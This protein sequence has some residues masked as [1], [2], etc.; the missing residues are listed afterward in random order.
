VPEFV[1]PGQRIRAA[2]TIKNISNT[3]WILT[4]F[5]VSLGCTETNKTLFQSEIPQ[6]IFLPPCSE[7][8]YRFH[9]V[10]PEPENDPVVH[11]FLSSLR[12]MPISNKIE[13]KIIITANPWYPDAEITD[14][15]F[16]E[17]M[18]AGEQVS[19]SNQLKNTGIG[20]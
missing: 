10:L 17:E 7:S 20:D 2:V 13:R 19:V 9:F 1:K 14:T 15:K 18:V 16:P 4:E 5:L 12:G 3:R 11:L 6:K 8:V